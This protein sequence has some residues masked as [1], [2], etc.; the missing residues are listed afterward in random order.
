MFLGPNKCVLACFDKAEIDAEGFERV[1][2]E[3]EGCAER[4]C[5]G[6]IASSHFQA[7]HGVVVDFG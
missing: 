2:Y 3:A 6:S 1:E 4:V 7:A 5:E